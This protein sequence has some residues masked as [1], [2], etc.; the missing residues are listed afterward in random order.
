VAALLGGCG[1]VDGRLAAPPAV[2]PAPGEA[3]GIR[4]TAVRVSAAGRVVDFRFRVTDAEKARALLATHLE[5]YALDQA[6]GT[7]LPV[8]SSGKIGPLRQS[9]RG[10]VVGRVYFVLFA[11]TNRVVVPGSRLT[12]VLGDLRL[13]DLVVE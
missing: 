5:V 4:V 7:K 9:A 8:P 12:V 3:A 1:G 13:P 10:A 11:N 2:A 6:T